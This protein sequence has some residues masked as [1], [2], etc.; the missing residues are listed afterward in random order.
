MIAPQCH[1][2]ADRV[3][4][5]QREENVTAE[6]RIAERNGL[7]L[8]HQF[9]VSNAENQSAKQAIKSHLVNMY[10]KFI[11][12]TIATHSETQFFNIFFIFLV[13]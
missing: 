12:K 11:T 2:K 1:A 3:L 10:N 13:L 4:L 5:L 8:I 7:I 6:Q 9:Q